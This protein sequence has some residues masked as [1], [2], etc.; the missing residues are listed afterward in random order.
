MYRVL[1]AD[2]PTNHKIYR[3]YRLFKQTKPKESCVRNNLFTPYYTSIIKIK[4][5]P[6]F[7]FV[8]CIL[9][10]QSILN[11]NLLLLLSTITTTSFHLNII[12]FFNI[13]TTSRTS[14]LLLL[15]PFTFLYNTINIFFMRMNKFIGN[16]IT[17]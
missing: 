14:F 2:L 4:R 15:L 7:S 13:I 6:K 9:K 16:S 5:K 3:S 8:K 11:L 10:V 1:E 12:Y 17:F